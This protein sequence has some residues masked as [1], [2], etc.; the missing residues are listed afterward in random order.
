MQVLGWGR[1]TNVTELN[2]VMG[3]K[4]PLN[5]WISHSNADINKQYKKTYTEFVLNIRLHILLID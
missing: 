1:E 3:S 5:K 4:T 2:R